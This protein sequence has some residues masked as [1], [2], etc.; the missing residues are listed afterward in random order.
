ALYDHVVV[1]GVG[2]P[3]DVSTQ[4][5]VQMLQ[6]AQAN[7]YEVTAAEALLAR[8]AGIPSRIGYGYFGGTDVGGGVLQVR[9][10]NGSTWLEAYFAGYGWQP[11]VGN[12]PRA[13]PSLSEA[14]KNNDVQVEATDQ[15]GLVV[16]MPAVVHTLTPAF[17][18]VRYYLVR[19]FP[20]ALLLI[21]LVITYPGFVK[22]SRA[23]RRRAWARKRGPRALVGVAYAEFRDR[24][25]DLAIGDL[26]ATP[27]EFLDEIEPDDEHDEL[28]W[29]VTRAMWGDYAG[30]I[31]PMLAA[32][33]EEMAGSV[34]RRLRGAQALMTRMLAFVTRASLQEPYTREVPN[35]WWRG[36]R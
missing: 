16:Y 24:A 22:A 18:I 34:S 11:I 5:V 28:A 17:V 29:L 7:P 31:T 27:L 26:L 33:A 4:R 12:P 25:R 1:A 13:K 10:G 8:W 9:P 36:R 35:L 19:A 3:T 15:F 14:K 30:D 32:E 20:F 21:T 6:G 23:R 2:K